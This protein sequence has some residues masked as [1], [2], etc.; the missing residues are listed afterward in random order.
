MKRTFGLIAMVVVWS[1]AAVSPARAEPLWK[2]LLPGQRVEADPNRDYML[3]EENGPWLIVATTF[4]GEGALDQARDLVLELRRRYKLEAYMH[5]MTFDFSQ[6]LTGRGLDSTGQPMR[7]RYQRDKAIREIAVLVGNLP[8]YDDP[9]G[10]AMLEKIKR[11]KPHALDVGERSSTSQSLAA[12]RTIQAA[13]LPSGDERK[14]RGPMGHAFI[15]RNPLLPQDYFVP[16]GLDPFV[17]QINSDVK[18]S[19][20][21]CKG[22]YT[23]TVAT[24][25]GKT[26]LDQKKVQQF[27]KGTKPLGGR[28]ERAGENA[29]K[30]CAAL[31]KKGYEAYVFH[32]RSASIVTIGSFNSLGTPRADGKTEINPK[33]YTIMRTFGAS[34]VS[35]NAVLGALQAKGAYVPKTEAGLPLDIQPQIVQVPKRTISGIA[36]GSRR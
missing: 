22:T 8:S 21:D 33:I 18:W 9:A 10:Q 23:V 20:L 13:L 26:V 5:E 32:D 27:L 24:Y 12:L 15:S 7:M 36:A 4:S 11:M 1:L 30:L 19:L 31:R 29:E 25:T 6:G 17:T 16:K 34:P 3:S 14:E 28:L 2:A 35:Q